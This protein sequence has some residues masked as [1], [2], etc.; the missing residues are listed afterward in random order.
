MTEFQVIISAVL[1][2]STILIYY[3][4]VIFGELTITKSYVCIS[5]NF[6][7]AEAKRAYMRDSVRRK[8]QNKEF[9]GK[10]NNAKRQKRSENIDREYDFIRVKLPIQNMSE[11]YKQKSTEQFKESC[12][13][14]KPKPN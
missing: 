10:E 4:E 2:M 1:P 7:K 14:L 11:N 12:A 8:R 13:E 5:I 3:S 9:R 6:S